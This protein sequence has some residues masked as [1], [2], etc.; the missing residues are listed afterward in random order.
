MV[1][2]TEEGVIPGTVPPPVIK[3]VAIGVVI[4]KLRRFRHKLIAGIGVA[5]GAI[6]RLDAQG[7]P[8]RVA[9]VG[10]ADFLVEILT[11]AVGGLAVDRDGGVAGGQPQH[12]ERAGNSR[13][14]VL[15]EQAGGCRWPF[16][17]GEN[18]ERAISFAAELPAAADSST[19]LSSSSGLLFNRRSIAL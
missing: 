12:G 16:A 7:L 19:R 8:D 17:P 6:H 2:A 4:V 14:G 11:P 10:N 13:L 15:I 9:A 5:G 1:F 3:Q 18:P